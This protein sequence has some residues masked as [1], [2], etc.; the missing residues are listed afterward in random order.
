MILID[1]MPLKFERIA[2]LRHQTLICKS[3]T[4][5]VQELPEAA[6]ALLVVLNS[7]DCFSY[8]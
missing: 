4:Y 5:A 7:Y 6:S 3:F 8:G 1:G 2:C